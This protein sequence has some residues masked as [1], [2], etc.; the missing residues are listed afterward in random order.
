MF[1][2]KSVGDDDR[3]PRQVALDDVRAALRLGV[4]PIPDE[5]GVAPRVHEHEAD[6]GE[7][8]EDVDDEDREHGAS[9]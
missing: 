9:G 3:E 1:V 2:K 4:K 6:Q 5:A 7:R 8:D